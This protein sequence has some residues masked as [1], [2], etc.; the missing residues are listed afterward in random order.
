MWIDRTQK[1]TVLKMAKTRP[2]VLL[3]GA[4]QTGK[5]SLLQRI[6]PS[7]EYV[8]FDYLHHVEAVRDLPDRFLR[9]FSGQ[10]ILDEIQYVPELFRG[11]KVLVD[12][13]RDEYGKWL[14]TGSQQF[15]LMTEISDTLAGRI[16][17]CHLETL[18][19]LEI[20][21]RRIAD[22][23]DH[24]WRGGY[25]E[26]WK[27]RMIDAG[28]FFESYIRTYVERDLKQIIDVR[29]L[30]DFRRFIRILAT[31][32]G[33][34]LNFR[35]IS[36]DTGVSDVTARK[37]LHAMQV[38]GL[39]YLLAPYHANI[40]KRLTK[41][42]KLFFADHGLASHLLG[43]DSLDEWMAHPHKGHLFENF[44]MMELVKTNGVT[45]GK[46]LF[47]YRDQNGVEIDFVIERKG[48][49]V[50]VEAK[51]GETIDRRKLNF[52]KVVPLFEKNIETSTFL[53][54]QV[55]SKAPLEMK[56]LTVV[57]PLKTKLEL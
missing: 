31:R 17:I 47:F 48:R 12:E 39:V 25:P 3:T 41:T 53:A 2:V 33:Q 5:S 21:H 29:N 55:K 36:R 51:S 43:V 13:E 15:E 8:T 40:G 27:N 44:V 14:L 11:L 22:V 57:N 4:R 23:S 49:L 45:P 35:D 24:L 42:P 18:S 50:F 19:A 20:R 54:C 9:R 30:T 37:W 26:L 34:L 46:D 52:Q 28:E 6:F 56:N 10:V 1:E 7:T 16:S 38:S 32:T